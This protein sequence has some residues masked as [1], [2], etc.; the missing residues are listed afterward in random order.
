MDLLM[1]QVYRIYQIKGTSG[2]VYP[3]PI[4]ASSRFYQYAYLV[5]SAFCWYHSAHDHSYVWLHDHSNLFQILEYFWIKA[6]R[7][8]KFLEIHDF[9]VTEDMHGIGEV[10]ICIFYLFL[11]TRT[12]M[13]NHASGIML[14]FLVSCLR[15]GNHNIW[16]WT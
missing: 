11:G 4:L 7:N 12:R 14:R 8:S 9:Y 10:F 15:L 6:W 1:Y 16:L 3:S 2:E 5:W 13:V